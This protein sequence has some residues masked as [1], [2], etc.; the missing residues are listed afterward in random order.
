[1]SGA[2]NRRVTEGGG[3]PRPLSN[4][5][6]SAR[7]AG[8]SAQSP[9]GTGPWRYDL[10]VHSTA[11]PDGLVRPAGIVRA[12]AR[13]GLG[14]VAL[15]DHNSTDGVREAEEEA[16]GIEGFLVVPGIEVSSS[17]GHIIGLG[18]REG[19][20]EG[21]TVEETVEAILSAGG[22]PVAAHPFRSFTGIGEAAVR[23]A[24]FE[25]VE[26][27]NGRSPGRK[28]LRSLRLCVELG[29]GASA[30]SDCHRPH[31]LGRCFVALECDPGGVDGLLESIRRGRAR[32][33]GRSASFLEVAAAASKIGGD[34]LRRG[35]RRI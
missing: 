17:G 29:L 22:L 20:E 14:G 24:R 16:R 8:R 30:G 11:S 32:P 9:P 25:A 28:N 6:G 4:P 3:E 23:S 34:W 7:A 26:V 12:A 21:L 35:G 27:L 10:H 15:T 1:M 33:S 2:L 13:A 18:V 5:A 19:I 31:E